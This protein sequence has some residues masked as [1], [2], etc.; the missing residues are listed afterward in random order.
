MPSCRFW[1]NPSSGFLGTLAFLMWC[2]FIE[3]LSPSVHSLLLFYHCSRCRLEQRI[4]LREWGSP[5]RQQRDV[6]GGVLGPLCTYP[7]SREW[8][9]QREKLGGN[10]IWRAG[11]GSNWWTTGRERRKPSCRLQPEEPRGSHSGVVGYRWRRGVNIQW[12]I[13]AD[14]ARINNWYWLKSGNI[15]G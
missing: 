15:K 6:P 2:L 3:V 14:G 11:L 9:P 8:R 13:L 5:V 10:L 4:Q 7:G 12:D 1:L